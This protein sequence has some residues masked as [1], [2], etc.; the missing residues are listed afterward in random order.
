MGKDHDGFLSRWDRPAS[1][2]RAQAAAHEA[3]VTEGRRRLSTLRLAWMQL[4][5]PRAAVGCVLGVALGGLLLGAA[6]RLSDPA[7]LQ[8]FALLVFLYFFL[9]GAY[10]ANPPWWPV[11][12]REWWE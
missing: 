2:L 8:M 11:R 10:G 7:G 12:R 3:S 1:E 4:D 9:S 5:G 6:Q